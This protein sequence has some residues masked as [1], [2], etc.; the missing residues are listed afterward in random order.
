MSEPKS[1]QQELDEYLEGSRPGQPRFENDDAYREIVGRHQFQGKVDTPDPGPRESGTIPDGW[2][3]DPEASQYE[4]RKTSPDF[5]KV[6][7]RML[8][9][10]SPEDA[11]AANSDYEAFNF[12]FA[13]VQEQLRQESEA[14]VAKAVEMARVQ[15]KE[16]ERE[17]KI[18]GNLNNGDYRT[19]DA[20]AKIA[21]RFLK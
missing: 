12:H 17:K 10:L 3:R 7:E 1:M 16:K 11:V 8:S 9:T 15:L 21:E 13:A 4:K 14:R 18:L 5:E 20:A 2:V 6:R 19:M